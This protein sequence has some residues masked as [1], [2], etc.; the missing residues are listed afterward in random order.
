MDLLFLFILFFL[1]LLC[2]DLEN[3]LF[4]FLVFYIIMFLSRG[5]FLRLRSKIM[6]LSLWNL[7]VL[8]C[9]LLIRSNWFDNMV[10]RFVEGLDII[11]I[12]G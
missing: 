12:G 2:L 6:D 7:L 8:L 10:E 11:L 3:F 9:G 1:E 5:Y 4:I